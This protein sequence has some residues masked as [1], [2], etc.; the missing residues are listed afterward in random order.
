[1]PRDVEKLK[2]L[3]G[4]ESLFDRTNLLLGLRM[5]LRIT[6]AMLAVVIAT[7]LTGLLAALGEIAFSALL[8]FNLFL[9]QWAAAVEGGKLY[10]IAPTPW[11]WLSIV[12]R[13]LLYMLPFFFLLSIMLSSTYSDFTEEVIRAN[14]EPMAIA[15]LIVYVLS[16]VPMG[17]ATSQ[18]LLASL[19]SRGAIGGGSEGGG[20]SEGSGGLVPAG[21]VPHRQLLP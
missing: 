3:A 9:Y 10:G 13:Q 20:S 19:R 14:P 16:V 11:C 2:R 15:N 1:M 5:W 6:L 17:L 21:R 7:A 8:V 18:A 12:W 4:F